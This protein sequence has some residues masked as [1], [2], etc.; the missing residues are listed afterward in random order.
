MSDSGQL[1]GFAYCISGNAIYIANG[2]PKYT[3]TYLSNI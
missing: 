1:P 3:N 2:V